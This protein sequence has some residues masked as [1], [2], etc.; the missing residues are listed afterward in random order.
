MADG[1]AGPALPLGV[2]SAGADRARAARQREAHE[3]RGPPRPEGGRRLARPADGGAGGPVRAARRLRAPP[4]LDH[5]LRRAARRRLRPRGAARGAAGRARGVPAPAQPQPALPPRAPD[6]RRVARHRARHPRHLDPALVPAVLD[7]PGDPR[8]RPGGDGPARQVRLALRRGHVRR[9]R[10]L[11]HLHD[12][13]ERV[14]DR[15]P[16]HRERARLEGEHA[17]HRL[18]AELRDGQVLR[19]R[20]VRGAALRREPAALRVGGGEERGVARVAEHRPE[21]HHRPRRD[22]PH[23]PRGAGRRRAGAHPRRPRARE[24]APDP[25]LHPA[26]L[27]RHGLPRDQAVAGRHGPHVPAAR[28]EPRGRRPAGR[29]AAAAENAVRRRSASSAST[30][31]TSPTARSCST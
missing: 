14:A 13:G 26:Q 6:R 20:G 23:D 24:R 19:Q 7:H 16:P 1:A 11:H 29:R 30:S 25:A 5:A 17:R 28:G 31:R 27:P 12:P 15:D 21:P 18:A 8:V 3:R 9:G 10:G 22:A 4:V 2:Q